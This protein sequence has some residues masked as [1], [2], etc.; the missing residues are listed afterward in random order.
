MDNHERRDG[1]L[2]RFLHG[3]LTGLSLAALVALLMALGWAFRAAYG[4]LGSL[5]ALAVF[6]LFW[7]VMWG[8]QRWLDRRRP[9][10]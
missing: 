3:E 10:R 2:H 7:L 1:W 4:W 5:G 6:V 9:R 8:G